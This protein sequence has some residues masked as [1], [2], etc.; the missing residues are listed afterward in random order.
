MSTYLV[1]DLDRFGYT[2]SKAFDD[3]QQARAYGQAMAESGFLLKVELY[4]YD[5]VIGYHL[6]RRYKTEADHAYHG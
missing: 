3:E 5:D 1:I 2:M 4:T 6:I